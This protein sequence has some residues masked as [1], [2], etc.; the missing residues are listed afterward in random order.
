MVELKIMNDEEY[1]SYMEESTRIHIEELMEWEKMSYEQAKEA[2]IKELE[3][4][5]P[6]G[7][8]TKDNF[9]MNIV[10]EVNKETV[11][12]IWFL[13]ELCEEKKQSFVCDFE[14]YEKFRRNGLGKATMEALEEFARKHDCEES[15]LWV[16]GKNTIAI[17]L[18][19]QGGYEKTRDMGNGFYM[20]KKL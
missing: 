15:V 4:M 20:I 17:R 10:D 1:N 11:G 8:Q 2:A 13:H 19:E 9:L 12:F 16:E 18:Y 3:E 7:L 5:L 14:I 6:D